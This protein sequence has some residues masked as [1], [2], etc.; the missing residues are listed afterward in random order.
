[1][2]GMGDLRAPYAIRRPARPFFL[3]LT[4][5]GGN[6]LPL[7]GRQGRRPVELPLGCKNPL[8]LVADVGTRF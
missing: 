3:V 7:V 1:S 5:Q 8:P 4:H 2:P 6:P